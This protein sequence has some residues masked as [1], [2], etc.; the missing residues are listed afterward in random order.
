MATMSDWAD[1]FLL[2]LCPIGILAIVVTAIRTAGPES[3][4]A[5]VGRQVPSYLPLC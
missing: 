1:I 2:S 3:L 5:L 4:K